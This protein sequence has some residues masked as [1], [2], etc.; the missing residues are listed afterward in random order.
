MF[1]C[2]FLLVLICGYVGFFH[3]KY[4]YVSLFCMFSQL[5]LMGMWVLKLFLV[6][7]FVYFFIGLWLLSF[8][9]LVLKLELYFDLLVYDS[10]ASGTN[11]CRVIL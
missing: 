5:T 1:L 4:S 9:V 10:V 2:F 7:F 8:G 6:S 3:F 11:Q